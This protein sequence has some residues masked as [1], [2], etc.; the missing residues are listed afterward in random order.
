M[1]LQSPIERR[2]EIALREVSNLAGCAHAAEARADE[3]Q[4]SI[5]FLVQDTNWERAWDSCADNQAAFIKEGAADISFD[6]VLEWGWYVTDDEDGPYNRVTNALRSMFEIGFRYG[7]S[8]ALEPENNPAHK[9][10]GGTGIDGEPIPRS[11][12]NGRF[13]KL[14]EGVPPYVFDL[15]FEQAVDAMWTVLHDDGVEREFHNGAA[16]AALQALEVVLSTD[17]VSA[18]QLVGSA[19][20]LKA[21]NR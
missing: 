18:S 20:A 9:S 10:E 1:T 14:S 8:F 3:L 13:V 12:V 7:A 11:Y 2:Q 4:K 17:E 15:L 5:D 21:L 6:M 19:I 16:N